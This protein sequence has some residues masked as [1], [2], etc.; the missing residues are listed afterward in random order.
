MSFAAEEIE[1][2]NARVRDLEN[3]ARTDP[4]GLGETGPSPR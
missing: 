1:R 2:L 4:H 3:E